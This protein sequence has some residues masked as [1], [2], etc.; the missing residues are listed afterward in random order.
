MQRFAPLQGLTAD[1]DRYAKLEAEMTG[2]FNRT[3]LHGR[4][5]AA[6]SATSN[7][8]PLALGLVPKGSERAIADNL[9]RNIVVK[10]DC[11]VSC[12]VIGI[13][14]LMRTLTKTGRADI[15]FRIAS[16]TTYPSWGYMAA[17]G[18]TTIWELWNGNTADPSMNSG[19]HVMLPGDPMAWCYECL[20]GIQCAPDAVAFKRLRMA[21]AF[22]IEG[23]DSADATHETPY[24]L[25]SSR[26]RKSGGSLTWTVTLPPNTTAELIL[27]D[28]TTRN[29]VS[30]TT[31]ITSRY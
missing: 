18:A 6:G 27:P 22:A 28:G 20:A 15:A 2:A 24:G 12:G 10:N 19:T 3:S 11:H 14:W 23:L 16:Q 26:W 7:L 9:A 29:I 8:L 30:G 4:Y 1:S 17:N 13:S 5:Y 25:V 31:T 21:P